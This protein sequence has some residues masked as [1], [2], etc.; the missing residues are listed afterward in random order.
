M[1]WGTVEHDHGVRL[2][3]GNELLELLIHPHHTPIARLVEAI[4]TPSV[5]IQA[6]IKVGDMVKRNHRKPVVGNP[7]EL[8]GIAFAVISS[9]IE[10]ID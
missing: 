2:L 7:S 1:V 8:V 3:A 5:Q 10:R 4:Q 6:R 9:F